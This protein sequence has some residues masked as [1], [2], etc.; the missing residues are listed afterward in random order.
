MSVPIKF[1]FLIFILSFCSISLQASKVDSLK[2]ELRKADIEE[3]ADI[4]NQLSALIKSISLDTSMIFAQLALEIAQKEKNLKDEVNALYNIGNVYYYQSKYKEALDY[5][6]LAFK[7]A[8]HEDDL[9]T[10]KIINR[11]GAVY[12]EIGEYSKAAQYY[13]TTLQISVRTNNKKGMATAYNNIGNIYYLTSDFQSAIEFYQKS[14]RIE[15]ELGNRIG[16]AMSTINIGSIYFILGNMEKSEE[17]MLK[18]LEVFREFDDYLYLTVIYIN[19]GQIFVET[20]EYKKAVYNLN[21]AIKISEEKGYV[22]R[23]SQAYLTLGSA[24]EKKGDYKS[25]LST[26]KEALQ[27]A[28]E[29]DEKLVELEALGYMGDIYTKLKK[30][31]DALY[32]LDQSE[33]IA[34]QTNNPYKLKDVYFSKSETYNLMGDYKNAYTYHKLYAF[35]NDS[36]FTEEKNRQITEIETKYQTE[37]KE[38]ELIELTA[39]NDK[40]KLT[41][42]KNRYFLYSLFAAILLILL[43]GIFLFRVNRIRNRQKTLELEQKLFRSQMN[44]HF[45]FNSLAAIQFYIT[46]NKPIEA[47]A[48]LSDF[49]KLM[50]LVIEN[51]REEYISLDQEIETMKYYLEMQKLRFENNF[52]DSFEVDKNLETDYVMIPP[53]LTQ[54][55]IENALEHAFTNKSENNQLFVRYHQENGY[56][57]VEVEDN[58]IG[59]KEALK[60]KNPKHKSFAL[61]V[62]KSRLEKLNRRK[63]QKIHFELI[64]LK[65]DT[66]EASGTKVKFS[67]PLKLAD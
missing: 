64:D 27:I 61:S 65:S 41:I 52:S 9:L 33:M 54:P 47:S 8:G 31:T 66:G 37:K 51:S 10:A 15:E 20:G 48:F 11:K 19:L 13:D 39:E 30:Y 5:F 62:T 32:C 3:K 7:R 17:Y 55:F 53:M 35:I 57:N 49:A 25:A 14:T 45:I 67:I 26:Y 29:I 1:Y 2:N 16:A 12:Q 58:G 23:K 24:Y 60:Q 56:L 34:E 44:P 36:V 21:K 40:N 42:L 28:E 59:R 6:D 63:S 43:S 4:L 50:R 38:K 46:K 22:L 18:A